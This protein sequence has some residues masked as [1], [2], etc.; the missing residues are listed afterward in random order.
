MWLIKLNHWISKSL[1][2][3]KTKSIFLQYYHF[4][5]MLKYSFGH[6]MDI[7]VTA[8]IVATCTTTWIR[9]R[10]VAHWH[11]IDLR[12]LVFSTFLTNENEWEEYQKT[13]KIN[14][15]RRPE[16]VL[17]AKNIVPNFNNFISIILYI[18]FSVQQ[19]KS[20]QHF[21]TKKKKKKQT[22]KI[23][24]FRNTTKCHNK[25]LTIKALWQNCI[26]PL[27]VLCLDTLLVSI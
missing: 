11:F 15:L 19:F 8:V 14:P 17:S 24:I 25:R 3:M 10:P 4:C 20:G 26:A 13:L 5:F 7:M 6:S 23:D 27:R 22:K 1:F 16:A 18:I 12:S 21:I 2:P 9:F